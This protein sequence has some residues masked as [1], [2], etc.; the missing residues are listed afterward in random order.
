MIGRVYERYS[1][2]ML[3]GRAYLIRQSRHLILAVV[4]LGGSL[5]VGV[6]GYMA[7]D[8]LSLVD[9]F[10]NAAMILGG[11]GPVDP[12]TNDA[13]KWFAGLYA[14]YSGIVFLVAVAIIAAPAV[15][16]FLHRL[17]VDDEPEEPPDGSPVPSSDD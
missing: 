11:M 9:A 6:L 12:L 10:V 15:H 17:H 2:P 3:S 16:R 7:L 13:A 5:L 14:L 8:D 4:V 1:E